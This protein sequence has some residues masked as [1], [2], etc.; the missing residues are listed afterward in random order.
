MYKPLLKTNLGVDS[1]EFL[2]DPRLCRH[3]QLALFIIATKNANIKKTAKEY[4]ITARLLR[5][6]LNSAGSFTHFIP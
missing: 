6:S 5:R 2:T 4:T 1:L 3:K